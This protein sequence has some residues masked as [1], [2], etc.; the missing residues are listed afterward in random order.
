MTLDFRGSVKAYLTIRLLV[1]GTMPLSTKHCL[2][3]RL[4]VSH[5]PVHRLCHLCLITSEF[6]QRLNSESLLGEK[7][8]HLHFFSVAC[9]FFSLN[10]IYEVAFIELP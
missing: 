4:P 2:Y 3:Q 8:S 1:L 6:I 10:S 7:F 5:L 9:E